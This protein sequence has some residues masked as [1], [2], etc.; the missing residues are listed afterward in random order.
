[1]KEVYEIHLDKKQA[2]DSEP[3]L[4]EPKTEMKCR[5]LKRGMNFLMECLV[6]NCT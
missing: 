4:I 3:T 6:L 5:Y 1:M 2:G